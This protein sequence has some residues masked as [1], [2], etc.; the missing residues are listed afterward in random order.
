[1]KDLKVEIITKCIITKEQ[2]QDLVYRVAADMWTDYEDSE[3]DSCQLFYYL[4]DNDYYFNREYSFVDLAEVDQDKVVEA[5]LPHVR[6]ELIEIAEQSKA[7]E[8]DE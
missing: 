6:K 1:M 5:I 3:C 7:Y 2:L 4:Y 8:E